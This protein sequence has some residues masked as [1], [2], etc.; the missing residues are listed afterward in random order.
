MKATQHLYHSGGLSFPT[1]APLALFLLQV[2]GEEWKIL[3]QESLNSTKKRFLF[4]CDAPAVRC[5]RSFVPV[6]EAVAHHANFAL[7]DHSL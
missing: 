6:A 2:S 4:V 3:A 7:V 1:L 5:T